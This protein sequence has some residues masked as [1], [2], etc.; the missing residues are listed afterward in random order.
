MSVGNDGNAKLTTIHTFWS[1]ANR[2]PTASLISAYTQIYVHW[3]DRI[4]ISNVISC[5]HESMVNSIPIRLRSKEK[6][7][8]IDDKYDSAGIFLSGE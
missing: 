3:N 4:N 8:M 2:V 7:I 1:Q 6:T 5:C